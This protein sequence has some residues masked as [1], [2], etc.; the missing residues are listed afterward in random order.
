MGVV[1]TMVGYGGIV[2]GQSVLQL[3]PYWS[4]ALGYALGIACSYVLNSRWTFGAGAGS[5]R[6]LVLF[7]AAVALAYGVNLAV[8]YVLLEIGVM[9]LIAQA[10]AMAVYTVL[11]FVLCRWVVFRRPASAS[12]RPAPRK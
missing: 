4:N 12:S 2:V 9:S 6:R 7:I 1:N 11:F 3:G 8:L 10:I 5:L